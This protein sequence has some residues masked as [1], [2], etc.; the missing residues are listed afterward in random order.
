MARYV[1]LELPGIVAIETKLRTR[2]EQWDHG[3]SWRPEYDTLEADIRAASV[4]LFGVTEDQTWF[5]WD[6]ARPFEEYES[7]SRTWEMNFD[8]IHYDYDQSKPVWDALGW[9]VSDG[10][11]DEAYSL[12]YF[13]RQIVGATKGM[14]GYLPD[15]EEALTSQA[16]RQAMAWAAKLQAGS[17]RR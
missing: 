9:D 15:S 4:T 14:F 16:E 2:E 11:G 7:A 12:A 6:Y 10:E 3:A 1:L 13:G 8:L 17:G 5:Q